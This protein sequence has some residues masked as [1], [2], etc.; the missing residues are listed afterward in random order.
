MR[1]H[2]S[3][4]AR[5][6]GP[7]RD[8]IRHATVV[9]NEWANPREAFLIRRISEDETR[10]ASLGRDDRQATHPRLFTLESA[11]IRQLQDNRAELER[12]KGGHR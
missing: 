4:V 12:L 7:L 11:L 2:L 1:T 10:L 3:P 6:G 9:Q 8:G 5:W